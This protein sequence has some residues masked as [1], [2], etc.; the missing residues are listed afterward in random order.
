MD[1]YYK[2]YVFFWLCIIVA[3]FCYASYLET[4]NGVRDF[5]NEQVST[6]WQQIEEMMKYHDTNTNANLYFFN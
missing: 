1:R 3:M 6:D 2:A 5:P 4:V